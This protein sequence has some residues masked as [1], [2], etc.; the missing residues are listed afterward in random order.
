MYTY[1]N[2]NSVRILIKGI[3]TLINKKRERRK[4]KIFFKHIYK[5]YYDKLNKLNEKN[6]D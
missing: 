6:F 3:G 1:T 5:I 2:L 4:K